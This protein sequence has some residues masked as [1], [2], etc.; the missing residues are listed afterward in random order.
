MRV[1]GE[2]AKFVRF[3]F[4]F[5]HIAFIAC[6]FHLHQL[7]RCGSDLQQWFLKVRTSASRAEQLL[8]LFQLFSANQHANLKST[9]LSGLHL[10][11]FF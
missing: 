11:S 3:V 5:K 1:M 6:T 2:S 8:F 9:G 4:P 7:V 10:L